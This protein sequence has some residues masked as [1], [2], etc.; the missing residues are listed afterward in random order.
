MAA[1]ARPE[2][3]GRVRLGAPDD[4]SDHLLPEVL[5]RFAE[6]YPQVQVLMLSMYSSEEHVYQALRAGAAGFVVKEAAC[7]E[8]A[9]AIRAVHAGKTYLSPTICRDDI[10]G[11][12]RRA[13][14]GQASDSYERLTP[15]ERTVMD[16]V[17]A[18]LLNK[19]IA[20][21]LGISEATVKVHRGRVMRK[22][23]VTSVAEEGV[24]DAY[25]ELKTTMDGLSGAAT[26]SDKR[27]FA[28]ARA[29]LPHRSVPGVRAD[30]VRW[31]NAG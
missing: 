25:N 20:S 9:A 6:A 4:F 22:L 23:G 30:C 8:L 3:S 14:E 19:Q 26:A 13:Q 2:V 28:P 11:Y 18:G 7:E 16:L 31:T 29:A 27:Q 10:Q 21:E 12:I 24:K 15:R 1:V 17:V 5:C